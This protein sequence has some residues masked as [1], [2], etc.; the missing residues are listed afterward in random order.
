MN[1]LIDDI[2]YVIFRHPDLAA[3]H[4]FMT[5][6]GLLDAGQRGDTLYLRSYGD[7]P[8]SYVTTRGGEAAFVGMGFRVASHDALARLAARFG[9]DIVASPHPGGGR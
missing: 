1:M 4:G 5:D 8:F 9:A 3:V 6:F 7:A 2:A